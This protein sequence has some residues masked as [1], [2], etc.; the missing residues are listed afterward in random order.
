MKDSEGN[1]CCEKI[2]NYTAPSKDNVK[3][4]QYSI[5]DIDIPRKGVYELFFELKNP[6]I[7]ATASNYKYATVAYDNLSLNLVRTKGFSIAIR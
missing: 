5:G 4:V 1:K 2:I 3:Y 6:T 7:T